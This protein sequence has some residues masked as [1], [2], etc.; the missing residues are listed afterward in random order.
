M[1]ANQENS[2]PAAKGCG[3]AAPWKSPKN[4][5][6]HLAWKSA[7]PADFHFPH[8]LGCYWDRNGSLSNEHDSETHN[9]TLPKIKLTYCSQKMVLT[10]G[11]TFVVA[12]EKYT[13]EAS[14]LG[15]M[16]SSCTKVTSFST[17]EQIV[18]YLLHSLAASGLRPWRST[19]KRYF[20]RQIEFAVWLVDS[21]QNVFGCI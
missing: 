12:P 3:K 1:Q 4:G 16:I 13:V 2:K 8:S 9:S 6:S 11:S 20:L 7:H 21:D 14:I 18:K 17:R 10:L 5:L 19:F 15:L